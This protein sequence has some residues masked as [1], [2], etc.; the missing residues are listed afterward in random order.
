M[1]LDQTS[2]TT[3]GGAHPKEN[4]N[5]E[6]KERTNEEVN[7]DNFGIFFFKK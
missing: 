3:E 1:H 4:G 2:R 6:N 5:E 7:R